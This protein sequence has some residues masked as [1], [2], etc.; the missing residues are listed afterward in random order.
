MF[1]LS[2]VRSAWIRRKHGLR[3][4]GATVYVKVNVSVIVVTGNFG[5]NPFTLTVKNR[6]A[7]C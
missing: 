4:Y 7:K 6:D 1:P 2:F 5:A 3:L